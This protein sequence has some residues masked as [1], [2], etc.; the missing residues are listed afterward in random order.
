MIIGFNCQEKRYSQEELTFPHGA[1]SATHSGDKVLNSEELNIFFVLFKVLGYQRIT[2]Q[3]Y[4]GKRLWHWNPQT[5]QRNTKS[6]II[7]WPIQISSKKRNKS[8]VI[9]FPG[10]TPGYFHFAKSLCQIPKKASLVKL[11]F[12]LYDIRLPGLNIQPLM[13]NNDTCLQFPCDHWH[14]IPI[15][16]DQ[17]SLILK[18]YWLSGPGLGWTPSAKSWLEFELEFEL[19]LLCLLIGFKGIPSTHADFTLTI[20]VWTELV[21]IMLGCYHLWTTLGSLG[22]L[23]IN[24]IMKFQFGE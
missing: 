3:L 2:P 5:R 13:N 14:A 11:L 6:I 7:V 20:S 23:S 18:A 12:Y 21:H 4:K 15:G 22:N 19:L 8:G 9:I 16:A 1:N 17:G 24:D 10:V